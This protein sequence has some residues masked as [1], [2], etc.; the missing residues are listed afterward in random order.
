MQT[1]THY[2]HANRLGF[3]LTLTVLLTVLLTTYYYYQLQ[4]AEISRYYSMQLANELKQ[5]SRDLT[6][7]RLK[8]PTS[9]KMC[10]STATTE[11]STKR[12]CESGLALTHIE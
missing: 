1:L 5:S 8:L 2:K 11:L 12:W 9:H 3:A 4:Q 10:G 6:M 7:M